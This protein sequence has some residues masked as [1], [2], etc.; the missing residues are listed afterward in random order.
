MIK[1]YEEKIDMEEGVG[2]GEGE[3]FDNKEYSLRIEDVAWI[4]IFELMIF[5]VNV[6]M[7]LC[8]LII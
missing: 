3:S 4:V 6:S 1:N 8:I 2:G 5:W 7:Y